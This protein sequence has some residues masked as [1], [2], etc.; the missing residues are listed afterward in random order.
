[1]SG[2][3]R[4]YDPSGNLIGGLSGYAVKRATRAALLSAVE[5]VED[6]RY[7]VVWWDRALESGLM[8]ADFFPSP[9]AVAAGS[10]LFF[11]YLAD[12]GALV[13]DR[14]EIKAETEWNTPTLGLSP[15]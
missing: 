7:E 2:E 10:G 11:D 4:I 14:S 12:A 6:L 9:A 3:I 8:P 15:Y 13:G 1:M 5:G